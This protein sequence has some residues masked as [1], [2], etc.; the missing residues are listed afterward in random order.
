M[1]R[2]LGTVV[3]PRLNGLV[4]GR[5]GLIEEIKR[6]KAKNEELERCD[7]DLLRALKEETKDLA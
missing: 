5:Q 1:V 4:E 6:R 2:K 3:A 7:Q